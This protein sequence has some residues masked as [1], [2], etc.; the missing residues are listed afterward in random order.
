MCG[1]TGRIS[2]RK[3]TIF[4]RFSYKNRQVTTAPS[5]AC[6]YTYCAEAGSPLQGGYNTPEIDEGPDLRA[7]LH[8]LAQ[9]C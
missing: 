5:A 3:Q 7:Q 9:N 8:L 1:W 6:T 2:D 4:A